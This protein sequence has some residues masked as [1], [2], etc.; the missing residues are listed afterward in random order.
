MRIVGTTFKKNS[1][2]NKTDGTEGKGGGIYYICATY[3]CIL[4]MT[5]GNVFKNN[6]ADNAGGGIKWDDLE[7]NFVTSNSFDG[8]DAY[9]YGDDIAC[10]AQMLVA[11]NSTLFSS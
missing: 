2:T 9:L 6:H 10:F 1:A 4:D 8:N 5:G 11:I 3:S 7:P